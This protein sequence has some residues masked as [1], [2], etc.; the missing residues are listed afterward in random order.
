M[1]K[2]NV[3]IC[4]FNTFLSQSQHFHKSFTKKALNNRQKERQNIMFLFYAHKKNMY[5]REKEKNIFFASIK[6]QTFSVRS[7]F[8]SIGG[9]VAVVFLVQ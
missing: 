8:T 7:N 4:F 1:K 3:L 2:S 5:Q 6:C 9:F